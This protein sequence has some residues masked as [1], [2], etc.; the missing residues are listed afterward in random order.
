MSVRGEGRNKGTNAAAFYRSKVGAW[1]ITALLDGTVSRERPGNFVGNA[2]PDAVEE[3][4]CAIG[5]SPGQ[6]TI[7]F[8]TLAIELPDQVVL[9][10][11]GFG[12]NGPPTAGR[13]VAALEAAGHEASEVGTVLLTH[14][15]GD[16]I[17]G[18]VT[19]QDEPVYPN[20]RVLVPRA[21]WAFWMESDLPESAQRNGKLCRRV[22]GALEGRIGFFDWD[23]AVLPGITARAAPGHTPGHTMFEIE[24]EGERLL[25]VADITNN[26]LIFARRPTWQAMFDLDVD[27]AV[28]T[29]QSVL[30]SVAASST[31][32]MFYH[33]PFPGIGY[34]VKSGEGFEF[35]PEIWR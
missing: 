21:E 5:V 20:A 11:A 32:V 4:F 9:I 24:S 35:M 28:E 7:T 17:S 10:D 18:L 26:P 8:T 25:H 16:H 23:Q 14:F 1:P 33:A 34:M 31:R 27:H 6:L 2:D 3:A 15:H 22:F 13:Q 19:A 12:E 29:R 30:N